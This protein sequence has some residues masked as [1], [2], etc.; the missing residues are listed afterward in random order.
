MIAQLTLRNVPDEVESG[1]RQKAH[2]AGRSLNRTVIE[3]L[4]QSLAPAAREGKKRDL[5][6]LAGQWDRQAC[7]EFERHARVFEQID[8]EVW[9]P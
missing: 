9:R 1:L 4:E 6:R 7:E 3:L 8:E 5:S 2:A